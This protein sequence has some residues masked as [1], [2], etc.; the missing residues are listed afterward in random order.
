MPEMTKT[1]LASEVVRVSDLP[2]AEIAEM[3]ALMERHYEAVAADAFRADLERKDEVV[4]L[5]DGEGRL[6]GFTTIAWNPCGEMPE[7]DVIFSGDTVIARE[8]WGTQELVKGFCRR[9]G[10]RKA[11]SGRPLYWFLISKGHRTYRYLPLFAKRFHPHPEREEQILEDLA[12]KVAGG[13]FGDAWKADEGV[14]R[15]PRSAGQLRRELAGVPE[16]NMWVDFFLERN[17]GHADGE[18][19]VCMAEMSAGNLRKFALTAFREG[20]EGVR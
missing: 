1:G 15:F 4:M 16:R 20:L 3:F 2:E 6:C 12:G 9:A 14:I 18:E 7:G 13:L 5:R 11:R 17:P 19:L 10:E 8:H